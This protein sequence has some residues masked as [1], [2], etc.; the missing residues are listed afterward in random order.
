MLIY[1]RVGTIKK[2]GLSSFYSVGPG[3]AVHAC[4][5]YRIIE[6][7]IHYANSPHEMYAHSAYYL[8]CA[9][10]LYHVKRELLDDIEATEYS[11]SFGRTLVNV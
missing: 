7:V 5:K 2:A 6:R 3:H 10:F 1:Q 4:I 8:R 9:D 11:N